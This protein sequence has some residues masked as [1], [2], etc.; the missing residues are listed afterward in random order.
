MHGRMQNECE[1]VKKATFVN[2]NIKGKISFSAKSGHKIISWKI[3]LFVSLLNVFLFL[4]L[5][6]FFILLIILIKI[7]EEILA[8]MYKDYL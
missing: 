1:P 8:S 5:L 6:F 2:G 7:F 3:M 4:L